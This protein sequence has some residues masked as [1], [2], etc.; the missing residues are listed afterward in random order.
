[1]IRGEHITKRFGAACALENV[2][3]AIPE[4]KIYGLVGAN[5]AGKSTLLRLFAG[6]YRPDAGQITLDGLPLPENP[7]ARA[8]VV[9]VPDE[10]YFLPQGNLRRMAAL[11]ELSL[12]HI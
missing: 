4:G 9:L 5:G 1:M 12:I 6:I 2:T 10:L 8:R 7:S 11:Y 3:C